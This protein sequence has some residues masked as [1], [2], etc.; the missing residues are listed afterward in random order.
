VA[1]PNIPTPARHARDTHDGHCNRYQHQYFLNA[2]HHINSLS[3]FDP[4]LAHLQQNRKFVSQLPEGQ[5]ANGG[6]RQIGRCHSAEYNR[7]GVQ[8][9]LNGWQGDVD[10]RNH[11]QKPPQ[12]TW[13]W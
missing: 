10:R 11:E 2:G 1:G 8:I 6:G 3:T 9:F 4:D 12:S 5:Q 13:E 7:A